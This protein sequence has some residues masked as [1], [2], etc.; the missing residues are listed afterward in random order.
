MKNWKAFLL[1]SLPLVSWAQSG[2]PHPQYFKGW[3]FDSSYEA[4]GRDL[5]TLSKVEITCEN[6]TLLPTHP[7]QGTKKYHLAI[8][9]EYNSHQL[10]GGEQSAYNDICMIWTNHAKP[11]QR[12][13]L[14]SKTIKVVVLSDLYQDTCGN[15]YRGYFKKKFLN[16]DETMGTLVSLGKTFYENP[17]SEFVGTSLVETYVGGTYPMKAS[18]FLYFSKASPED[19]LQIQDSLVLAKKNG[20]F[21]HPET[22]LFNDAIPKKPRGR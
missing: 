16:T 15:T 5:K 18:E 7:Q 13:C 1:L 22:G 4:Y 9:G 8:T 3:K 2:V 21:R 19:L 6:K 12:Y 10:K 11:E 14:R 20:Q 17:Y